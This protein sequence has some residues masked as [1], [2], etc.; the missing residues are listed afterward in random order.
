M[1]DFKIRRAWGGRGASGTARAEATRS[2][3]T[4]DERPWRSREVIP[5]VSTNDQFGI[6][7]LVA[8]KS[9]ER[10][11]GAAAQAGRELAGRFQPLAPCREPAAAPGTEHAL[12]VSVPA[13]GGVPLGRDQHVLAERR[14]PL[15][16]ERTPVGGGLS[17]LRAAG[18]PPAGLGELVA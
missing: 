12:G 14:Q 2:G 1:M 9:C 6:N 18:G 17:V 11:A 7:H 10:S 4:R 5:A 13:A 15:T 8:A 16:A 3:A